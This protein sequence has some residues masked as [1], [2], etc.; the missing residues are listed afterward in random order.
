MHN[1]QKSLYYYLIQERSDF[2]QLWA[3]G[4]VSVSVWGKKAVPSLI[5]HQTDLEFISRAT[6]IDQ[7]SPF[8][9]V[10]L[11]NVLT[12]AFLTLLAH[13]W[14]WKGHDREPKMR[15]E[16]NLTIKTK[17]MKNSENGEWG[18]VICN[19]NEMNKKAGFRSFQVGPREETGACRR[20]FSFLSLPPP[21]T[22]PHHLG[23]FFSRQLN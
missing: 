13:S 23:T 18:E 14:R 20:R 8:Y 21:P 3:E 15:N 4:T 9:K 10:C 19:Q 2:W 16:R 1:S 11:E 22:K 12:Q 6:T 5:P 7:S 17:D